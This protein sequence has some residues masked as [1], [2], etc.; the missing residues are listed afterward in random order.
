MRRRWVALVLVFALAAGGCLSSP[1][2]GEEI[3]EAGQEDT[4]DGTSDQGSEPAAGQDRGRI[5]RTHRGTATTGMPLVDPQGST[6]TKAE[7]AQTSYERGL[8]GTWLVG[9][10]L[11]VPADR[12]TLVVETA[13]SGGPAGPTDYDLFLF[14]PD[15]SLE[16]QSLSAASSERIS[17]DDPAEGSHLAI[18]YLF[19]GVQAPVEV[20]VTIE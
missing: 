1:P 11:A 12:E 16:G 18:A 17:V 4:G 19:S 13:S 14:G 7:F 5:E 6:G 20:T 15:G 2:T 10:E 3:D 9:H 8:N